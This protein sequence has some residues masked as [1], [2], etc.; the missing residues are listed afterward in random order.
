[1]KKDSFS[2]ADRHGLN[3][4]HVLLAVIGA[5]L[6]AAIAIGS[7]YARIGAALWVGVPLLAAAG[8]VWA[9]ARG[10]F[11]AH[12]SL[13]V[14]AMAMVALQIH[15]GMG[16]NLYHFG[17]FVLLA[18]LLIYRDWRVIVVAAA[19]G[20]VHHALFNELQAAGWGVSCF[21]E[22]GRAQVLAHA[23][24]V[25]VQTAMEIWI[26][27]IL[28]LE[29]RQARDVRSLVH[30]ILSQKGQVNLSISQVATSTPLGNA[31]A[32]ALTQMHD[33]VHQVDSAAR[34]IREGSQEI[35]AGNADLSSRAE[36]QAAS[37]ESTGSSIEGLVATVKQNSE[38][39]R[40]ANTLALQ[41]SDV[42]T[43][44]GSAMRSVV[45]TMSN[46]SE[47]SKKIGDI[48]GVIDGIA[49][50]TN[51]LALNAAVEA[52]RAGEQGRGFA[53]VASEVRSLAQRCAAA[54]KETKELIG[55]SVDGVQGGARLIGDAG[56]T[57][58]E[59]VTSVQAMTRIISEIAAASQ[60][61]LSSIDQVSHAV[62]KMDGV[63][64]HNAAVVQQSASAAGRMLDQAEKLIRAVARFSLDGRG[65]GERRAPATMRA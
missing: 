14:A 36:E 23:V 25:I 13:G 65:A 50:Q 56:K 1:M 63:S 29:A 48:I 5:G 40:E 18:I 12:I 20:A 10:T 2:S 3:G 58:D 17:V 41:A 33:A 21:T 49:F 42:A 61:Q 32:L 16:S 57:M 22:P 30:H 51:I 39:A 15:V 7:Q 28:A 19:V 38:R 31:L 46:I 45:T 43:R 64:Q 60:E 53:V 35:A 27:Q 9:L 52:A 62:S 37:L 6:V 44:G 34:Q 8:A 24:Y 54:A 11:L 4:D 26:A 59:L 55:S 47:S